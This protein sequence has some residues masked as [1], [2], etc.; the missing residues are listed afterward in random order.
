MRS[1]YQGDGKDEQNFRLNNGQN[2][3]MTYI[4][5]VIAVFLKELLFTCC[6]RPPPQN[7]IKHFLASASDADICCSGDGANAVTSS[8]AFREQRKKI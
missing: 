1:T 5:S 3:R 7:P 4:L 2:V 6:G 8:K